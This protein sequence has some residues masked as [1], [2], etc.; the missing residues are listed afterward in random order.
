MLAPVGTVDGTLSE[1]LGRELG[2]LARRAMGNATVGSS[3]DGALT[4]GEPN[5]F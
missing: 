1:P 5:A 4:A 3:D 2:C